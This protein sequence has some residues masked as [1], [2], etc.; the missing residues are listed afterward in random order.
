MRDARDIVMSIIFTKSTEHDIR[1]AGIPGEEHL[2][3]MRGL[4]EQASDIYEAVDLLEDQGARVLMFDEK[5]TEVDSVAEVSTTKAAKPM[6]P[7]KMVS[8]VTRII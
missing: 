5:G 8:Q 2:H 3:I 7:V 6:P 4:L 1:I